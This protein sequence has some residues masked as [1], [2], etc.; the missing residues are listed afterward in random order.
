ML[1]F[2]THT[3]HTFACTHR[4]LYLLLQI[5]KMA[6][7]PYSWN[8]EHIRGKYA[9]EISQKKMKIRSAFSP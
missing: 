2:Y 3:A 5:P 7:L 8:Q 6:Q 9:G 4:Q 1:R